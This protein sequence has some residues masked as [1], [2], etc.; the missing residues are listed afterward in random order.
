LAEKPPYWQYLNNTDRTDLFQVMAKLNELKQT[1]NEFSPET[2]TH[3][4]SGATKWFI[5]SNAGNHAIA[6]GNFGITENNITI[7]FPETGKYY[8]FFSGDSI[9]ISS[10]NQ[11]F[12]FAPGEYRLYSTQQFEEPRIVTDID[13]PEIRSSDLQVY[14]NPASNKLTVASDKT[15]STVQLYSIAGTLQYQA[16]DLRKNKVE[17]DVQN[18]TPGVY[19]IRVGQNGNS[20]TQKVL[21]K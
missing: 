2:F 9:E 4:L 16:N 5:S 18:F 6:L 14:P 21:V 3:S 17:I 11:S 13:E 20:I 15:I 10:T 12:T 1:Y 8:E 7:D 19:L